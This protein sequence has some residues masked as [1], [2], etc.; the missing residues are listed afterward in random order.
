MQLNSIAPSVHSQNPSSN[1]MIVPI[2]RKAEIEAIPKDYSLESV[3]KA[4]R[5]NKQVNDTTVNFSN[6]LAVVAAKLEEVK[7]QIKYSFEEDRR[8]K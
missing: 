5:D 1:L 3:Q 4:I 8:I 6:E 7:A 2:W